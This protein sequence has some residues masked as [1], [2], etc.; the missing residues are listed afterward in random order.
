MLRYE[1][2]DTSD[3]KSEISDLK[4]EIRD[5]KSEIGHL[6]Y[7]IRDLGGRIDTTN[8]V[9]FLIILYLIFF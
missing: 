8:F 4:S 7:D 2:F 5:L 1:D 3:L 9:I 6:E